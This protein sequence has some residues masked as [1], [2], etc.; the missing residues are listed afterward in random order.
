MKYRLREIFKKLYEANYTVYRA[1]YDSKTQ[2]PT[3]INYDQSS[4]IWK[5][6]Q[7]FGPGLYFATDLDATKDYGDVV[8]K[9]ELNLKNPL[10]IGSPESDALAMKLAKGIGASKEDLLGGMSQWVEVISLCGALVNTGQ[11][12]WKSV[13][14]WIMKQGYDSLI[15]PGETIKTSRSTLYGSDFN[16][17]GD[18]IAVLDPS[19]IGSWELLK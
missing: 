11:L 4:G 13:A 16:K 9:A 7:D 10:E 2:K 5:G 12:K 17:A 1:S 6:G 8:Y 15:I 18:Y 14:N 19:T 3:V